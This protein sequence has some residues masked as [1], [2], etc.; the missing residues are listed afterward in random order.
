MFISACRLWFWSTF[1]DTHVYFFGRACRWHRIHCVPKGSFE[2]SFVDFCSSLFTGFRS[3]R[4]KEREIFRVWIAKTFFF[5][6]QIRAVSEC[7]CTENICRCCKWIFFGFFFIP[8]PPLSNSA[9]YG[10]S[11]VCSSLLVY[12]GVYGAFDVITYIPYSVLFTKKNTVHK[13]NA[14]MK[15]VFGIKPWCARLSC[16]ARLHLAFS[17]FAEQRAVETDS[18]EFTQARRILYSRY[19]PSYMNVFVLSFD[20]WTAADYM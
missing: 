19:E 16:L 14:N 5:L 7:T 12:S 9:N 1:S 13:Q 11:I 17:S 3:L 20:S 2:C 18:S 6:F 10:K 4:A 15:C 8:F